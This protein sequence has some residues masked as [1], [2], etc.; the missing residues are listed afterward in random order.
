MKGIENED[1]GRRQFEYRNR[2]I[3]FGVDK[4]IERR[5]VEYE[6]ERDKTLALESALNSEL[7]RAEDEMRKYSPN[8]TK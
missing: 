8:K 1:L 3:D 5:Q 7:Q 4:D 2:N 6:F